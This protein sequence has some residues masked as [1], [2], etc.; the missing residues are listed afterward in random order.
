MSDATGHREHELPEI[1]TASITERARARSLAE[2][3]R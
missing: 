2:V 3:T 1:R